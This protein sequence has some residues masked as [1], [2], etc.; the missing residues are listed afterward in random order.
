M[1]SKGKLEN[2][3]HESSLSSIFRYLTDHDF[4]LLTY[5]NQITTD[6]GYLGDKYPLCVDLP[7]RHFLFK[8]AT[9][10]L[11][12]KLTNIMPRSIDLACI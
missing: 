9:F 3:F 12:G 4:S 5:F 8:G 11:L 1:V 7:E 2:H 6:G 10:R